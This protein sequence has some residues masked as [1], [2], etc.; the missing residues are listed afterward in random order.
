MQESIVEMQ[1]HIEEQ[2]HYLKTHNLPADVV[3][4][5]QAEISDYRAA[6]YRA[7]EKEKRAAEAVRTLEDL[8]EWCS[9][10]LAGRHQECVG[11]LVE[12]WKQDFNNEYYR[13][14]T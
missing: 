3:A 9:N 5:I 12:K 6:L 13:Y 10:R 11:C 2:E 7:Q 4:D 14:C 8:C 1:A